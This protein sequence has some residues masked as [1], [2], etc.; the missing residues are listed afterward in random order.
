MPRLNI[1]VQKTTQANEV[2][3]SEN[4]L[5]ALPRLQQQFPGISF[6]VV[7]VQARFT[8]QQIDGVLRTL[9]E[10]IALTAIVMLFFLGSWRSSLVVL[11][12]I[13]FSLLITL[14]VMKLANFTIDT[15]TLL[16]MTLVVGIL[17]DDSI[18]VLENI[19]RHHKRGRAAT[20]GRYHGRSE[21]GFAAIVITLVD[22][23]VFLPLAFLPGVVGRFMSEF[24]VVVVVATL[25]SLWTSFTVTPTLAGRWSLKSKWKPWNPI[26]AFE[27]AFER[28][29]SWY[30]DRL[31][32]HALQRPGLVAAIAGGSFLLSLTLLPLGAIGFTFIPTVDRRR[33]LRPDHLSNRHSPDASGRGN[34]PS[35]KRLSPKFPTLTQTSPWQA[36][37]RLPLAAGLIEGNIGQIQLWLKDDRK[38]STDYWVAYL[39]AKLR[40]LAPG[41]DVT[42]IPST[43]TGGGTH[44][45]STTSSRACTVIQRKTRRRSLRSLE[46][47]KA[48]PTSRAPRLT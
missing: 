31:L 40:P 45:L 33:D 48:R 27:K 2:S 12:A 26:V 13:P 9:E 23:V 29:R 35:R 6:S 25:T 20:V 46:T 8:K 39:K 28:L 44:N 47:R 4:V 19:E 3:T 41:A 16:A 10:G 42:V 15:V 24:G 30:A 11:I 37:I 32:P 1:S 43:S 36:P 21:I 38:Q 7:N 14:V 18:V 22:V 5:K 17:V 34:A